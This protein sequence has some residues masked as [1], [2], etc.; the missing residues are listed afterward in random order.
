MSVELIAYSDDPSPVEVRD[1]VSVCGKSGYVC[2]VIR[3]DAQP[4]TEGALRSD[5][6]IVGWR[7]SFFKNRA[8]QNAAAAADWKA[9]SVLE[10]R[11]RVGVCTLDVLDDPDQYNDVD[12]LRDLQDVY[13][14]EYIAYRRSSCVCWYIRLVAG[15]SALS[16]EVAEA[17]IRALLEL[18]GGMFEDPQFGE[19]EMVPRSVSGV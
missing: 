7:G 1:L 2:R 14:G 6:A 9:I 18:R 15:R 16:V 8:G 11:G 12:Q 3:G 5:D 13:G 10:E 19:F 17:V 4:V